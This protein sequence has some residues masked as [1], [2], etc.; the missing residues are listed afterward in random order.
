MN[1]VVRL[2]ER[3]TIHL[4][5]NGRIPGRKVGKLWTATTS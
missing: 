4:L 2:T 5:A 3:Q 1:E